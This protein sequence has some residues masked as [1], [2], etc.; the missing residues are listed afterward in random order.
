MFEFKKSGDE[1]LKEYHSSLNGLSS[2][3]AKERLLKNGSNSLIQSKEKSVFLVF[4]SQFKDLLVFILFIA[5]IVSIL[6][7]NISSGIVILIVLI[8]NAILGTIQQVKARK[9]L[10]AL[11]NLSSPSAK[12]IRDGN[13]INIDSKDIVVGDIVILE[14]GDLIV[15]DGRILTNN[16]LK[17]N[18]SSITGESENVIKTD[19]II[20][21]DDLMLAD[22]KNM[23]FSG[24][25]VTYGRATVLITSTGMDSQIGKIAN[26]LNKTKPTITPLHKSLNKFSKTLAVSI[27]IICVIIFFL[28]WYRDTS[29]PLN[30]LIFAVALAVAAIPEALAS[31]VT[32]VQAMGT[33]KMVKENAIVKDLKSVETLGSINII[34][35][36][37]TGTLT[38]NKM[39][40]M[41]VYC[42]KT[43]KDKDILD[44]KNT[45]DET[46]LEIAALTNDSIINDDEQIG[47]PTEIALVELVNSYDME[48]TEIRKKIPRLF[49]L[50]FD[51]DRKL[52]STVHSIGDKKFVFTKG[53][54]DSI[55][56]RSNSIL[57]NCKI[58][59]MSQSDIDDI[60]SINE[61]LSNDGLRVL[62]FSFRELDE[63]ETMCFDIENNLTF[64]G[65]I[66]MMDPPREESKQAVYNATSAGIKT[67]MIT[68]DHK[69][70]AK[71]IAKRLGIFKEGDLAIDGLELKKMNDDELSKKI[72]NISVF[73]RVS[74]SDKIRIVSCLQ[75]KGFIV[76]MTGDGVND[77]PALKKADIGI[78]MGITG[79]EVAKEASSIILTDDNF[80]T[81][82]KA[83]KNGRNVYENIKNS[84]RFL[85]SGNTA[86]IFVVLFTVL[87]K[88]LTPPFEAVQLLFINLITDS[89]PALAIGM[90]NSKDELLKQPP[91]NIKEPILDRHSLLAIGIQGFLISIV[92][93]TGYFHG[94][95]SSPLMAST[96]AFSILTISR[97]FHGFNCRGRKNIFKLGITSNI[98]SLLA[99]F[100]GLLL[101]ILVLFLKPLK[102]IF[103]V[104]NISFI[105]FLFIL[106]LSFIPTFIIQ[107]YKILRDNIYN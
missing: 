75:N 68:G 3:E 91:R 29:N 56:T 86:A 14:A 61:R 77:A 49:E 38:Q 107:V 35:S 41:N 23:V 63:N 71:A 28:E 6:S 81:I 101:V 44:I 73:A 40:V 15:A 31:I 72:D 50:P 57:T 2:N 39:S 43:L 47:D 18:E 78:S 48:E 104:G 103:V 1:L 89:L 53:A 88:N 84:I 59:K 19:S 36:D 52:M 32:I 27:S 12:V 60:N 21:K 80:A 46:L 85:L 62:A 79:T 65:L 16:S 25:F 11:K 74:P 22:Q 45:C 17:V 96:F 76:S 37:K 83:V 51:S 100:L 98:Y 9:S 8:L 26:F 4:L 42:D 24:S 106:F 54:L 34:C 97:L 58:Q 99:F 67:I 102:F 93:L 95:K 70:T 64:V 20:E 105:D 92:T 94:L 66:S 69:V 55:L 30:A 82:I 5:V 13:V 87:F 7:H 33:Q 10:K 90:E